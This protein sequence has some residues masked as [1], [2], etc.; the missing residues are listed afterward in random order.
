[1]KTVVKTYRG[2]EVMID[3]HDRLDDLV[4]EV[5]EA[6]VL[7]LYTEYYLART[8]ASK[9][10]AAKEKGEELPEEGYSLVGHYPKYQATT[11]SG[12][13]WGELSKWIPAAQAVLGKEA[14]DEQLKELAAKIKETTL[15]NLAK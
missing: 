1:M 4:A 2:L 6:P 9:V 13:R 10:D 14:T 15:A 12:K 7:A 8:I 11:R 5:G 3:V